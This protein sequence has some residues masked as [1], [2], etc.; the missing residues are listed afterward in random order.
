MVLTEVKKD[1]MDTPMNPGPRAQDPQKNKNLKSILKI[2][3]QKSKIEKYHKMGPRA[4]KINFSKLNL[5]GLNK[6]NMI[7]RS[8][9]V[10]SDSFDRFLK[11]FWKI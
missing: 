2:Q 1:D 8:I 6:K 10:R 9:C 11:I 5:H 7:P 4:S 3:K